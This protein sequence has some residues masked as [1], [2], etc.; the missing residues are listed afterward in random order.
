MPSLSR[1]PTCSSRSN[2]VTLW[3][4]ALSCC[5]A[6][7]PAGPEP[8]TATVFPVRL[9]GGFGVIHPSAQPLSAIDFS[10][11]SIVTGSW[12]IERTHETSHGAG[13]MRPVNSGKALVW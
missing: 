4:L 5:A 3:P 11:C 7:S 12:L 9:L 2:T 10:M 1:P 6:A 8:T 13:Q